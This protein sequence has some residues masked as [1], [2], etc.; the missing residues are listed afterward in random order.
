[1][2]IVVP[3]I[4]ADATN[5][6]MDHAVRIGKVAFDATDL[7]P[8]I[9]ECGDE[10]H[11]PTI[12]RITDAETMVKGKDLTPSELSMTDNKAVV[13][14]V[15]KA[16]RIYDKD[17]AQTKGRVVDLMAEQIGETMADRVDADLVAEMDAAT[18][19]KT[20]TAKADAITYDEVEK[21]FDVFGDDVATNSF[22]GI[23]INSRL[24][25]SFMAMPQF[26]KV[27]YTF[28]KEGNGTVDDN[29]V[30]GYWNGIIPVIV[31]NNNTYDTAK[32]ECK[33]YIVKKNALGIIVQKETSV[34]EQR[35][36]LK[37][38]TLLSADKL[39]AVKLLNTKGCA[40]LRKTIA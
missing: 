35:E 8:D 28:A 31:C 38:A 34:E 10:V 19:Y 17:A 12:D 27:D 26:T 3:G 18:A 9:T 32:S 14:Q 1:M 15:G 40:I 21:G 30:I 7:V 2:A 39:Y 4:F 16:V 20:A 13:R 36:S 29:G 6:A 33:T 23:I 11:F 24:R 5:A 37:K 22:A 25:S